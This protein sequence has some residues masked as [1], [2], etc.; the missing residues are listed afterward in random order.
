NYTLFVF[1]GILVGEDVH[2][3]DEFAVEVDIGGATVGPIGTGNDEA[4]AL[5]LNGGLG[6][7]LAGRPCLAVELPVPLPLPLRVV[8]S[9]AFAGLAVI[10]PAFQFGGLGRL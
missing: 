8:Y 2:G 6:S 1:D 7:F 10:V 4:G 5:K 9:D 3:L